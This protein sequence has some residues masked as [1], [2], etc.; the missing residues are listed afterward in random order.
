M[1]TKSLATLRQGHVR[2]QLGKVAEEAGRRGNVAN[3][4]HAANGG[5]AAVDPNAKIG[6]PPDLAGQEAA[7]GVIGQAAITADRG[8]AHAVITAMAAKSRAL[9]SSAADLLQTEADARC[10]SGACAT[11][12]GLWAYAMTVILP[13]LEPL[14]FQCPSHRT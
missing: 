11:F 5:G 3:G 4:G 7:A 1:H 6:A 8:T 12:L 10:T 2:R 14:V 13:G 9:G